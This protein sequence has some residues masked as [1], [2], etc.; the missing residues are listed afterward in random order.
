MEDIVNNDLS[1]LN[2]LTSVTGYNSHSERNT[3]AYYLLIG[4]AQKYPQ[5]KFIKG[6]REYGDLVGYSYFDH[7]ERS[8]AI[9]QRNAKKHHLN[10]YSIGNNG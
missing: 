5:S 10:A 1:K 4:I 8:R 6:C 9:A 7:A 3:H 2:A